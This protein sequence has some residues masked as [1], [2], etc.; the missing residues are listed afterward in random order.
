MVT[1]TYIF[2]ERKVQDIIP[3]LIEKTSL[4]KDGGS[5]KYGSKVNLSFPQMS[6]QNR[7]FAVNLEHMCKDTKEI[8]NDGE[9]GFIKDIGEGFLGFESE[10][11][12]IDKSSEL[13]KDAKKLSIMLN[14]LEESEV[15]YIWFWKNKLPNGSEI[16][17]PVRAY[18][19]NMGVV[20]NPKFRREFRKSWY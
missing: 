20:S 12:L 1:E 4:N 7:L 3:E 11:V 19:E 6:S 14:S 13:T 16:Y 15:G 10:S 9:L 5:E 2:L 8:N 18:S 17:T